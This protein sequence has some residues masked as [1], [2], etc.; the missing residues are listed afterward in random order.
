[1][2]LMVGGK[3]ER[4]RIRFYDMKQLYE[5]GLAVATVLLE[6]SQPSLHLLLVVVSKLQW[7]S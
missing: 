2:F 5:T 4:K 6:R 7:P 1:M 3:N